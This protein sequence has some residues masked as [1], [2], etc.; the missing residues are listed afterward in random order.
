MRMIG[1]KIQY[2]KLDINKNKLNWQNSKTCC[3]QMT[4]TKNEGGIL[5]AA[6][7]EKELTEGR[8]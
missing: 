2:P 6:R 8:P 5:K 3:T 4:D 1:T 7:S